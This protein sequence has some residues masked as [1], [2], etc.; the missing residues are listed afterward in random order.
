MN[1][2]LVVDLGLRGCEPLIAFEILK[3]LVTAGHTTLVRDVIGNQ[4]VEIEHHELEVAIDNPPPYRARSRWLSET[5]AAPILADVAKVR[6]QVAEFARHEL[7]GFWDVFDLAAVLDGPEPSDGGVQVSSRR[8]SI[9]D[10]DKASQKWRG[11]KGAIGLATKLH[12]IAKKHR[13]VVYRA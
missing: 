4:V 1:D 12:A 5:E 8:Y 13:L 3:A 6:S 10:L 7:A 11:A 9:V 2:T